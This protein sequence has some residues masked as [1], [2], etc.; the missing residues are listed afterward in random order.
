MSVISSLFILFSCTQESKES[1][2]TITGEAQGTTY[3]IILPDEHV[4]LRKSEI[5]S[6]LQRFDESLSTYLPTST[7]SI[8]N[9]DKDSVSVSDPT[10]YFQGCYQIS[11]EVFQRTEG[12]FDPSVYPLVKGW[13]FT[14]KV[15]TPLDSATVDSL[16]QYV[17]FKEDDLFEISFGNQITLLK[18]DGFKFDFNAV[19]QGYSVDVLAEH[20]DK[21]R[22]KDYY[23]EIGGELRVKGKNREGQDWRIGIDSPIADPQTRELENILN[24]SDKA[25]ATSGN[26][27]NFYEKDG[28]KYAHTLNPKTGW[29]VQ[30]S[31]LSATVVTNDCARADAYATAF[32]VVGVDA[33]MQMASDSKDEIEVYLLYAD[34]DGELARTYSNGFEKYLK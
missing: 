21:K 5:D 20:L 8:L 24:L 13:G 30:H 11:Q 14:D 1:G 32:M 15:E 9:A 17:S 10:G 31:L 4:D 29:P 18:K 16:L 23:I 19:A 6:I 25:V 12:A 34:E 33:A 22:I 2:V 28:V 3:T 7:I 26:Y 27:R